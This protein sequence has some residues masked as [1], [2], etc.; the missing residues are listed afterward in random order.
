[1]K[2]HR[3]DLEKI[4]SDICMNIATDSI[5]CNMIYDLAKDKYD[6]PKGLMSDLICFRMSMSETSEFVLF[7]LLD[8]LIKIKDIKININDFYTSQEIDVYLSSKY[9]IDKIK[10][11][12]KFKMIQVS[13]DQ[14]VGHI[15][16]FM[17]M[18]LRAAQKINY[19]INAQR[20]MQ[21][22]IRGNKEIYKISLN[23]GAVKEITKSYESNNFIPNTITL[24]IPN[25]EENDFYYD[26]NNCELII[27]K[28]EYFHILDA[29][30]RFIALCKASDSDDSFNYDMELRIVNWD[31][32]KS[33]TFIWQ[34]DKKTPLNKIDSNS[35]NMNDTANIIVSRI[36]ESPRC[37]IKGLIN[38]NDGLV[39]FGE[40]SELIKF[41]YL[42]EPIKKEERN[43]LIVLLVKELTECFNMITEFDLKYLNKRYSYKQ[44]VI[45][46]Y[47]FYKYKDKNKNN[48]CEMINRVVELQDQLDNK[49]FYSKIPRKSM[50]NEIDKLIEVII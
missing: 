26:R 13:N 43:S 37:N 42:K 33:Q 31:D 28:L 35:L 23:Q 18:K 24:N 14:W 50:I 46:I 11:P 20:T 30:H 10:F 3:G 32:F 34:E 38:R 21:R 17:L 12:L 27:N 44:L 16:S 7:C 19:N 2:R 9:K 36:N 25:N 48:M 5:S 29:Y 41:F 1:M 45:I 6:I 40:L 47:I 22:I 4:L 49:K 8:S 39:N 15:D